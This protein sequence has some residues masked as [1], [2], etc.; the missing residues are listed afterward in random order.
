MPSGTSTTPVPIKGS[1]SKIPARI[2]HKIPCFIPAIPN[3]AAAVMA[4]VV[5]MIPWAFTKVAI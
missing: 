4:I 2:P 1:A 5:I 3:V